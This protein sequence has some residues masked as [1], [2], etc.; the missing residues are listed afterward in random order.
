MRLYTTIAAML[1]AVALA[2][3]ETSEQQQRAGTGALIGGAGGALVGQAIGRDTKSTLIGAGAGALLGA[4][5]GS[6]TTRNAAARRCAVTRIVLAAFIPRPAMTAII[7][8]TIELRPSCRQDEKSP[9]SNRGF[10]HI[11]R[12]ASNWR[13]ALARKR[14]V[15]MAA[16]ISVCVYFSRGWSKMA[17]VGPS[18]TILPC[19]MT[20]M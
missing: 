18:S 1:M 11:D 5:V 3:C 2:G 13:Q 7:T 4:A 9:G 12:S 17:S 16:V 19:F 10:F 14:V 20:M 6:S 8:A 15:S